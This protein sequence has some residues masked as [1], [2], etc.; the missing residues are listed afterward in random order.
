MRLFP[1]V[2]RCPYDWL[3][4]HRSSWGVAPSDVRS[5]R[6]TQSVRYQTL[7]AGTRTHSDTG[8]GAAVLL[9][10]AVGAGV[11]LGRGALELASGRVAPVVAAAVK[12]APAT[13]AEA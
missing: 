13:A 7:A 4:T 11:A 10:V 5:T 1:S 12:P 9:G 2:I 6:R 3:L 8:A